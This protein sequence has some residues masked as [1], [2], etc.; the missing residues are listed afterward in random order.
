MAIRVQ[1]ERTQWQRR[2]LWRVACSQSERSGSDACCGD[3]RAGKR[4]SI[5]ALVCDVLVPF[6]LRV[7]CTSRAVAVNIG[8]FESRFVILDLKPLSEQQKQKAI[9]VQMQMHPFGK[10]FSRHLLAFSAIRAEHD[11]IYREVAFPSAAERARIEVF[12]APNLQ[13]H[14][15]KDGERD[16]SMRQRAVNGDLCCVSKSPIP[17]SGYLQE[18]NEKLTPAL[19]EIDSVM[20]TQSNASE[21]SLKQQVEQIVSAQQS[22][23]TKA[24]LTV[25][26]RLVLLV[27]KRRKALLARPTAE[28]DIDM[29]QRRTLE[30][31]EAVVP[32]TTATQLWPR[33]VARTDQIYETVEGLLPIFMAA[34]RHIARS[35]GLAEADLMFASGLKDPVRVHE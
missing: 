2:M 4:D 24:L 35:A 1:P 20:E 21:A 7:F 23:V 12:E 16:Q 32:Q 26:T 5:S 11:R 17:A 18:L 27:Q 31:I 19:A 10:T 15:G 34:T 22:S 30:Y 6:G 25:A 8:L 14:N 9:E 13:F 29:L 3:A 33:I 28:G